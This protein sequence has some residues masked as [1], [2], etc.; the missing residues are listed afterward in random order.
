MTDFL[1]KQVEALLC[2]ALTDALSTLASPPPVQGWWQPSPAGSP[3]D[4][5]ETSVA[6]RLSV[7]ANAAWGSSIIDIAGLISVKVSAADDL[8]GDKLSEHAAPVINL[9]HAWNTDDAAFS[10]ALSVASVFRADG[11]LFNAGADP[12][13]DPALLVWYLPIPFTI[14]GCALN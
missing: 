12:D 14:K 2:A 10:S 8:T 6:V 3:K 1:E 11:F 9:L 5:P 7:R 4:G 13:L